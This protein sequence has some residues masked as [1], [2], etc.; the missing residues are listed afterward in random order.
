[1][2]R[3]ERTLKRKEKGITLIALVITIIVLLIL[4]GV[5]IAMLTGE[6]GI[7]TQAQKAKNKTDEA[8][9][10]EGIELAVTASKLKNSPTLEILKENLEE[11]IRNQFGDDKEF[12]V[13]DNGDGSFLISMNDTDRKYYVENT[14]NVIDESKMLKISSAEE[15][16]TFKE[17]VN[18]GNTYEGWYVYLTNAITLDINEKWEPIGL[19]LQENTSPDTE[20]NKPFKGIFDGNEYEIDGIYIN[21]TD[22]AQGLFG[23]V[24]NGKILNLGIG[25]NCSIT[26]TASGGAVAGYLCNNSYANNCYNKT[27]ITIG[28]YSG[29]VFGQLWSGTKIENCYNLGNVNVNENGLK[30]TIGGVVG[31][32][33]R[34]ITNV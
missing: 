3:D 24:N 19:Y 11:E 34:R 17:N 21:T 15:L 28:G 29:G 5:S 10:K 12:S 30:N 26:T 32:V 4:A 31:Q 14:G 9:E 16:E 1:M 6:N 8:S 33:N 25:E 13:K 22:K 27:D 23:L 20:T 2:K 18:S 7:L